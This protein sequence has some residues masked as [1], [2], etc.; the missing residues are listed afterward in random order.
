MQETREEER[1]KMEKLLPTSLLQ[2]QITK[3]NKY[4]RRATA[5]VNNLTTLSTPGGKGQQ[6]VT[7]EKREKRAEGRREGGKTQS[8]SILMMGGTNNARGG[9]RER[10]ARIGR[11]QRIKTKLRRQ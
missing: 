4:T 6:K 7:V 1:D 3:E 11:G 5:Q 10:V 8:T 9:E 2:P